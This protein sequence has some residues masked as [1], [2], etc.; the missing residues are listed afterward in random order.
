[1]RDPWGEAGAW[2]R[3]AAGL[4]GLLR[5]AARPRIE[6]P[7]SA[8]A[9]GISRRLDVLDVPLE[10]LRKIKAPLGVSINDVVLTAYAGAEIQAIYP[11]AS[12]VEKTPVILALLSYA[13]QMHFGIDTDPEAIP[14]PQRLMAL[15]RRELDALEGLGGIE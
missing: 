14:D 12:P 4:A 2:G 9:A 1:M 5:D 6:D 3:T 10:R 11:F 13:G 15:L 7:L 8:A